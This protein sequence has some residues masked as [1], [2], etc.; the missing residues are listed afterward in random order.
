MITFG[1]ERE[2]FYKDYL[3]EFTELVDPSLP[4]DECGWLLEARS[5]P[6]SDIFTAIMK[7]NLAITKLTREANDHGIKLHNVDV[8]KIPAMIIRGFLSRYGKDVPE[9]R[10]YLGHERH[11]NLPGHYIAGTHISF[12]NRVSF[13]D[14]DYDLYIKDTG[15][16]KVQKKQGKKTK[17]NLNFDY[18]KYF[19]ALDEAFK[20]EIK[21]SKRVPGMYEFK[22]DGRIE[23]RSLPAT[24]DLDKISEVISSTK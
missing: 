5:E 17:L 22:P 11:K 8:I 23:Y 13:Y 14:S 19:I 16:V 1:L 4:I 6:D 24:A 15:K 10:N 20:E 21:I 2:F 18:L 9:Y 3:G 7:L 12:M